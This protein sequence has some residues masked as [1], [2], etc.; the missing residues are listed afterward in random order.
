MPRCNE[1]P[2]GHL[3]LRNGK[4]RISNQCQHT[5]CEVNSLF[6]ALRNA[7]FVQTLRIV[8]YLLRM[9]KMHLRTYMPVSAAISAPQNVD[10]PSDTHQR[11]GRNQS[12]CGTCRSQ[13]A[14]L[15]ILK[16]AS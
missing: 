14:H 6:V 12:L 4:T 16:Q 1:T 5:K 9:Q 11:Q 2:G 8:L 3:K 7:Q 15:E 10:P 13:I